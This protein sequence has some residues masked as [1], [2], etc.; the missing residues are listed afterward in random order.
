[1]YYPVRRTSHDLPRHVVV[2]GARDRAANVR[3]YRLAAEILGAVEAGV[4]PP[5][6]GWHCQDCPVRSRLL[7]VGVTARPKR[8]SPRSRM[9]SPE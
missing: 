2:C 5:R 4:F 1:L 8:S 7:G 9:F 3:F 6:V